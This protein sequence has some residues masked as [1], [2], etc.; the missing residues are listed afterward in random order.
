MGKAWENLQRD[1]EN[2]GQNFVETSLPSFACEQRSLLCSVNAP[3]GDCRMGVIPSA[4]QP[5]EVFHANGA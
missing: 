4:G 5:E 1:V 2:L 3:L